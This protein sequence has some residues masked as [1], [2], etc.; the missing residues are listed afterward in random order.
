MRVVK[1]GVATR[2]CWERLVSLA[3]SCGPQEGGDGLAGSRDPMTPALHGAG[4]YAKLARD[5]EYNR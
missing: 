1:Y 5:L 2:V 3:R 4:A